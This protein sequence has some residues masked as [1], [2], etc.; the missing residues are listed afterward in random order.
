M[1][2]VAAAHDRLL[3]KIA[4]LR[5]ADPLP[6]PA[7]LHDQVRIIEVAAEDW[8]TSL[9][10]Q[11]FKGLAA[12]RYGAGVSQPL[13][14]LAGPVVGAEEVVSGQA[15]KIMAAYLVLHVRGVDPLPDF[16]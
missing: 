16:Q 13:P 3:P 8:R 11:R 5:V 7:D 6:C 9:H 14:H 4:A 1:A 10:A 15:E 2:Q 12:C